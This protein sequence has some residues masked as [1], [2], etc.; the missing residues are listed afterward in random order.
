MNFIRLRNLKYAW[1]FPTIMVALVAVGIFSA[2]L[3][4]WEIDHFE[5]QSLLKRSNTLSMLVKSDRLDTFS[6]NISDVENPQYKK[7]K[8]ELIAV[9]NV[10]PDIRFI[11]LMGKRG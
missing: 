2:A 11:Y 6:G 10:N 1:Y 8:E 9:R 7:L 3:V 5:K 4:Y